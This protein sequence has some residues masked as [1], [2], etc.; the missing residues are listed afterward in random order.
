METNTNKS[1]NIFTRKINK[2]RNK[3]NRKKAEEAKLENL[4]PEDFAIEMPYVE[5]PKLTLAPLPE[6][7]PEPV[8]EEIKEKTPEPVVEAPKEKI[9][10]DSALDF[11]TKKRKMKKKNKFLKEK[12]HE[13]V[14]AP[15]PEPVEQP[16][17]KT[18]EPVVLETKVEQPK[19]KTPEPEPTM[20]ALKELFTNKEEEAVV[21]EE[22]NDKSVDFIP[23]KKY[24]LKIA[25]IENEGSVIFTE[26]KDN[27]HFKIHAKKIFNFKKTLVTVSTKTNGV[28][29]KITGFNFNN[30]VN[31]QVLIEI[32]PKYI[33]LLLNNKVSKTLPRLDSNDYPEKIEWTFERLDIL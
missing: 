22:V 30:T 11:F 21:E 28:E 27:Y 2:R 13:P 18:P 19:E 7:V 5:V 32:Q 6:P 3:K 4:K 9:S 24:K 14:V 12:T 31:L 15:L 25:L 8:V 16:K 1:E 26:D 20:D 29:K 10:L 17:E 33:K 23:S